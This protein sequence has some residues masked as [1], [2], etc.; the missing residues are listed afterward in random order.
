MGDSVNLSI[1]LQNLAAAEISLGRL[2]DALRHFTEA[3][4]LAAQSEVDYLSCSGETGLAIAAGLRGNTKSAAKSFAA[5]NTTQKRTDPNGDDLYSNRG[6][7]WAEYLIRTGEVRRA[8]KLTDRNRE[9]CGDHP[10]QN[11]VAWCEW[12][13]GWLDVV[14]MNWPSAHHHLNQAEA[15]FTRGHM[16]QDLAR[17]HLTRAACHLGEGHP[18]HALAVCERALDLAAP[19]NYRLIHA[20]ALVLRARI[21]F[22]REDATTA[23]NDAESA[24]QIAEFCEYAW[25]ERDACEVLAQAWRA[26]DNQAEATRYADRAANLNRRLTPAVE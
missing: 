25:A 21:A 9:I 16:I 1:D 4:E 11:N 24:L 12:M 17:L 15:T 23:R 20:D 19:R 5:A 14:E 26:L 7:R 10:W 6:I 3:V 13:L 22:A 18:D 2:H 8:R